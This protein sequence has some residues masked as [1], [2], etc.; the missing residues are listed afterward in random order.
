MALLRTHDEIIRDS[1]RRAW[2][3]RGQAHRRRP[4]GCIPVRL[5][6]DRQR[7]PDPAAVRARIGSGSRCAFG[8]GCPPA[9]RSPSAATS[10]ARQCSS[11]PASPISKAGDRARS[12]TVRD[13]A[14]G[15]GFEFLK[16]GRLRQKGFP[17]P[18]QV[19]PPKASLRIGFA[20]STSP[21]AARRAPPDRPAGLANASCKFITERI[22]GHLGLDVVALV[23]H[24][25]DGRRV[26]LGALRLVDRA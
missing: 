2:W 4:D 20:S 19:Y 22:S 13:L 15:K 18:V 26:L 8:S 21:R 3:V 14:L 1:I 23:E 10:S 9:S 12:S 11:L 6:G 5:R 16:R 7:R 25:H 24:V 17:D